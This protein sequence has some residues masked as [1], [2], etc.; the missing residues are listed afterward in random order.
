VLEVQLAQ[1]AFHQEQVCTCEEL[2]VQLSQ[3][4][5]RLQKDLQQEQPAAPQRLQ[6]LTS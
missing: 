6:F 3:Q 4:H 1:L 5:G 2:E